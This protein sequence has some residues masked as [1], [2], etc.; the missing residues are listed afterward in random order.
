MGTI[1]LYWMRGTWKSTV[2]KELAE[3]LKCN[4]LD[5]DNFIAE[6]NNQKLS[7]YIE[8]V[9]WDEFRD[10]EHRCLKEVLE[11]WIQG[12]SLHKVISLWWWTIAFERNRDELFRDKN[13]K[14]VYLDT[15]LEEISRRIFKD[16]AS[17]EKRNSLTGKTV[18]EELKEVYSER[19]DIYKN[20]C[21]FWVDNNG[22]IESTV[23]EIEMKINYGGICI[24]VIH[25][26]TTPTRG[27]SLL[28]RGD[29]W[30]FYDKIKNNRKIEYIELRLDLMFSSPVL[31]GDY[32]D[33]ILEK[34]V[35]ECPKKVICTNRAVFEWGNFA[36]TEKESIDILKKC[37]EYW[38]DYIDI[39]LESLMRIE[40][41]YPQGAPLQNEKMI[42]SHHNFS[43][44]LKLEELKKIL[45]K[46]KKYSPAVYKIAM[47]P[48]NMED[49]EIMY[50]LQEHFNSEF[51]P[52]LGGDAWKA[53]VGLSIFISMWELWEKSR[54]DMPKM[55]ALFTFGSYW[56]N[57]SAPWQIEYSELYNKVYTNNKEVLFLWGPQISWSLSPFMHNLSSNLLK[58]DEN[59]FI[60]KLYSLSPPLNHLPC[61]KWREQVSKFIELLES[62]DKYLWGNV[63]MPYKIEVYEY[64]KEKNRLDKS[65]KLVWAVNTLY[66][67]D[68]KIF[69][70]N[71]DIDGVKLPIQ[72]KLSKTSPLQRGVGGGELLK[73][74]YILWAWWASRASIAAMIEIGIK[75]IYVLNRS[76]KSLDEIK[77]HFSQFLWEWQK[78][79][80]KIYNVED[81]DTFS[82]AWWEMPKGQRGIIINTLPFWFKENLPVSPINFDELEDILPNLTLYFEAVYDSKKGDTP[83]VQKILEY[84]NACRGAPCG[85]PKFEEI[86]IC[87][88]IEMLISQA[89]TWFELWSNWGEFQMKKIK[90]ILLK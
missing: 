14:I 31:K 87:R 5:L 39:E 20:S 13:T 56:E 73:S 85:Y 29:I 63:T 25:P 10:E 23:D 11:G 4:F 43:K 68:W 89:K 62:D 41:G 58:K 45:E 51:S 33:W 34:L 76:Q 32:G 70:S 36:W 66:K 59:K 30:N 27:A 80:T 12:S 17:G 65:A 37:L 47:M 81:W 78:I 18:L 88:G 55:W 35:K 60:Y 74:S 42:I 48:E 84:N 19:E 50:K 54:I 69:W 46:M 71:T 21:D 40:A 1:I 86:Q 57:S 16:E 44:T 15:D 8:S 77:K 38:A 64:L 7:D 2:G 9:W 53:E 75:N 6:K 3:R 61:K 72:E 90:K 28:R 49:V 82:L 24:P 52:L 83:L 22:K 26:L 79:I 67:K